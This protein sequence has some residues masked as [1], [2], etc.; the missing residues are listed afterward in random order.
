MVP[1]KVKIHFRNN[2]PILYQTLLTIDVLH[3]IEPYPKEVYFHNLTRSIISQ[4]L[5][6]KAAS[7]IFE[8]FKT[9]LNG[10]ITPEGIINLSEQ[11]LRQVGISFQKISYL[12]N[13]SQFFLDNRVL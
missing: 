10:E 5:S 4:Q 2:D 12:K 1:Q 3:Q 9:L 8:R 11:N 7:T 13:L 6:G